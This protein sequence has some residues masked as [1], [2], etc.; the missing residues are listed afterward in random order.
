MPDTRALPPIMQNA[1]S[2]PSFDAA[3]KSVKPAQRKIAAASAEPPPSPPPDGIFFCDRD[4]GL[5]VGKMQCSHDE[6]V[7]RVLDVVAE[8]A[9]DHETSS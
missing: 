4:V 2:A 6:I 3:I 9:G 1:I 5:T 7:A 8:L